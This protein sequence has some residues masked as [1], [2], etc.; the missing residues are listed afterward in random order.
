MQYVRTRNQQRGATM[1]GML[2]IVVILGLGL[3]S[4]IRLWPLYFEY[5][6][7]SRAMDSVAK[8][9]K[10]TDTDPGQ[11]RKALQRHWD[12]EDIKSLDVKDM[13]IKKTS[14]G[15]EMHAEYEGRTV[16]VANVFW[17]VAFD[18]TVVVN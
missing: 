14:A 9:T 5:Y 18:K 2:V 3:Y 11:L 16:F 13:E 8:D 7:I 6:S 17:V 12:I 1:L 15:Y 4:L 10:A